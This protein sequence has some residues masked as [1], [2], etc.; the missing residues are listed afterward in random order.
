MVL[1]WSDSHRIEL[2]EATTATASAAMSSV[3][4]SATATTAP[5]QN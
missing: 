5:R 4:A 2:R 1:A 3:T